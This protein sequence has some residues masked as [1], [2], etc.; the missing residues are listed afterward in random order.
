MNTEV[1]L[2]NWLQEHRK[3]LATAGAALLLVLPLGAQAGGVVTNCTETDL[4]AAMTG[5]GGVTFACDG[6]I[7]LGAPITIA[8]D[9]LIDGA[10]HQVALSGN[11]AV[12]VFHVNTGTR[13]TVA[14]LTIGDGRGVWGGAISNDGGSLTLVGVKFQNNVA[15][16]AEWIPVY[17]AYSEGGVGGAIY[18]LGTLNATN[19][20]FIGNAARQRETP[21]SIYIGDPYFDLWVSLYAF[22]PCQGGAIYSSG[23]L[24]LTGCSFE[25]NAACAA[26]G[27][28]VLSGMG[29]AVGA[30]EGRTVA[31]GAIYGSMPLNLSFC[32][33]SNN[34]ACSSRA[35]DA[36]AFMIIEPFPPVAGLSATAALGGAVH[37]NSVTI[38]ACSF[39]NNRV[40]GGAGGAGG[41]GDFSN[42]G[43]GGGMGGGATGGALCIS[44]GSISHS[45]LVGNVATG[46]AGG[47]GGYGDD[48]LGH[49]GGPGAA[50]GGARGG[51][52]SC[53]GPVLMSNCTAAG[54]AATGGAGGAGG[55]GG[56]VYDYGYNG[57]PGGSGGDAHG[58][59]LSC[60]GL[61]LVNS[62]AAGNLT[63][64]GTGG[65]GGRGASSVH[66]S[67]NGGAGGNGGHAY[68]MP[69]GVV[70]ALTN[71]TLALN[72]AVGGGGGTGGIA[73]GG[74]PGAP[75]G[76][77]NA[78]GG[79]RSGVAVLNCILA[80][81]QPANCSG[82]VN[83]IGH[84]LSSDAGCFTNSTSGNGVDPRLAPL[85]ANGGPTL[86]M[87]LL[88]GSPAIDA[89]DT[90][91]A[92]AT[93]QRGFPR[94][95]GLAADIG[96]FEYGSV[97]P[98]IA[99][100][101]SGLTGLN[102]LGSGNANQPCRLLSSMDLS[103]WVPIATNQF[104]G[105][106]TVELYDSCAQGSACRFYRLATP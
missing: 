61:A 104:G 49:D 100:S 69:F 28:T 6:T 53:S 96:A 102:I 103:S 52:L 59:A 77:G 84:N 92:P 68:A 1:P 99:I 67:G 85:V 66:M 2:N 90:S 87:A 82:W 26:P 95:A 21:D 57:G 5:G 8:T 80:T 91:L 45:S 83:D 40:I 27:Y 86:T 60:S 31:G 3:Q 15:R 23:A 7:K 71:C 46:G 19:C 62:T 106:G 34:V 88:P 43:A 29:P 78:Y 16:N 64:G 63:L 73:G 58:G 12:S 89:G 93:D 22:T 25:G 37:A 56:R 79:L 55:A 101:R 65:E 17:G 36:S 51:A 38:Y 54:N 98:T 76:A 10:G 33:F 75:G 70:D 97:M 24:N 81:N 48:S 105:D 13:L 11:G 18:N 47:A 39:V 4:R 74:S 42:S 44:G 94:P 41:R 30:T 50:G 32:T 20:A 35:I 72:T 9:T 14:N